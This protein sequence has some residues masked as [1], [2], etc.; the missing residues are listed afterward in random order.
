MNTPGVWRSAAMIAGALV[1]GIVVGR[2][3]DEPS[4]QPAAV[5]DARHAPADPDAA[6]TDEIRAIVRS[7]LARAATPGPSSAADDRG[8]PDATRAAE[9][10]EEPS[11]AA[12]EARQRG[13]AV[14]D[15]AKVEGLWTEDHWVALRHELASMTALDREQVMRALARAMNAGGVKVPPRVL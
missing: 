12:M 5:A 7:E 15:R 11:P 10:P 14:V 4:R 1:V 6:V 9:S 13:L 8:S 2:R 3:G